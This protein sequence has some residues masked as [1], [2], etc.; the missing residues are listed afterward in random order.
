MSPGSLGGDRP[1]V[2]PTEPRQL[3]QPLPAVPVPGVH[4]RGG[5][6]PGV[7]DLQPWQTLVRPTAR[8][9]MEQCEAEPWQRSNT[10]PEPRAEPEAPEG[11]REAG[12]GPGIPS[13]SSWAGMGFSLDTGRG[14]N[15]G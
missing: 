3:L 12:P 5:T 13:R 7:R 6:I 15:Q 11:L 4:R 9:G 10:E 14:G 2:L 1:W 8:S